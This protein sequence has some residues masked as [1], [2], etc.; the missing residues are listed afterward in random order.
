MRA[1]FLR[2]SILVAV[3]L[4]PT[5]TFAEERSWWPGPGHMWSDGFWWVFPLMMLFFLAICV[6]M[7]FA[8]TWG[9]GHMM[10]R[11]RSDPARSALEILNERFARS[12]IQ[13]AEY[14]EKKA[15]ILSSGR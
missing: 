4:A 13:K 2:L 5:A 10:D 12:E 3:L 8:R 6:A 14:E 1:S 9:G 7:L 15:A 11:P